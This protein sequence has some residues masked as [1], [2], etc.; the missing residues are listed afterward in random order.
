M[1]VC[2]GSGRRSKAPYGVRITP[3]RVTSVA[4]AGRSLKMESPLKSWPVLILKGGP[5][6][7]VIN[8]LN[9]I[10]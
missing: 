2:A 10:P 1:I 8:G 3:V 9:V 5:E 7:T 6:L 4:Q